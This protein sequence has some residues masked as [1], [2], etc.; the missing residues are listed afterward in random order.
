MWPTVSA[1]LRQRAQCQ[2]RRMISN[3]S[4]ILRAFIAAE[5]KRLEG[6]GMAHMPTLGKAYEAI[7]MAAVDKEFVLPPG[8]D[9]RV[10]SGFIEGSNYQFDCMLVQG[11]GQQYGLT[12]E[13]RYPIEKVLCVFEVKKTLTRA[14]LADAINHLA[15]VQ[16]LHLQATYGTEAEKPFSSVRSAIRSYER[17]TGKIGPDSYRAL[18]E[19][20]LQEKTLI[21]YL[22]RQ[23]HVPVTV[24]LGYDGFKTEAG[25]RRSLLKIMDGTV[26]KPSNASI[27][28]LPTLVTSG[29][30]S[31]VKCNAQPYMVHRDADS[32]VA[33]A[34]TRHNAAL[35]LLE[36]LWTKISFFCKIRMPFG[37]DMESENLKEL[38]A[39]QAAIH[40][41]TF[42]WI[43]IPFEHPESKLCRAQSIPWQPARVSP[44]AMSLVNRV[45]FG[46]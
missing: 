40:G 11:D 38:F 9:L 42:G 16:K 36:L 32:W 7:T 22:E 23:R 30:F 2:N 43:V 20:P 6:F 28:L 44:A 41:D 5:Q 33:A 37:D 34:S 29:D 27:D 46:G 31:I 25:L 26:G 10:V 18:D 19:M 39:L 21:G 45:A 13:Y 15:E 4:E 1:R 14:D 24:V 12:T 3:A 35:I 17:I 8:L